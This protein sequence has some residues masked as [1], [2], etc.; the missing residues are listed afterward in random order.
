MANAALIVVQGG[1]PLAALYVMK[2]ILDAVSLASATSGRPELVNDVWTW[3][4][5]AAGVGLFTAIARSWGEYATQAQS[6]QVTDA[7]SETLHAQSIAVDL[8]YYEDP[9]YYDTLHRA[10]AEAEYRPSTPRSHDELS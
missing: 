2:R 3:I 4:V 5:V 9:S 6:L 10:Q 1:L 7:V 8:A